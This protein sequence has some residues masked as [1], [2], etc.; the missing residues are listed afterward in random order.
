MRI[1]PD[2]AVSYAMPSTA[3]VTCQD[4]KVV[5]KTRKTTFNDGTNGL[6]VYGLTSYGK[7]NCTE[8]VIPEGVTAIGWYAFYGCTGLTSVTIPEGVTKI[9][10]SA[11]EGCTGLTSITI[12]NSVT[13]IYRSAF[14]GCTNLTDIYVDQ[15]QNDT[16]FADAAVPDGCNITWNTTGSGSV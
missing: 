3:D 12:P 14:S 10:S 6:S 5:F 8:I 9:G 4:G 13:K 1:L 15:P 16:L 11:F 2:F 7:V